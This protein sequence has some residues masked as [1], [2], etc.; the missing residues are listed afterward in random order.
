MGE[1]S[2][3]ATMKQ[4]VAVYQDAH[5]LSE[6]GDMTK[7]EINVTRSHLAFIEILVQA[8]S[9]FEGDPD[10]LIACFSDNAAHHFE[11][12]GMATMLPPPLLSDGFDNLSGSPPTLLTGLKSIAT[13][14]LLRC[15][16]EIVITAVNVWACLNVHGSILARDRESEPNQLSRTRT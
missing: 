4:L 16:R 1:R 6:A 15:L 14:K 2:G 9:H 7:M 12:V 11:E 8:T 13:S 10:L 5:L 3:A